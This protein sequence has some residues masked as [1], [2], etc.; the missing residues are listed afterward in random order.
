MSVPH[1]LP[2]VADAPYRLRPLTQADVTA[3]YDYLSIPAVVEHTSWNL[4]SADDLR[5][6][7]EWYLSD[8]PSSAI[9]FAIQLRSGGP[10]IGTIGFHTISTLNRSAEIAYDLH[11]AHWGRGIASACCRAVVKWGVER[12]G[13]VRVQ[14]TVLDTNTASAR[15]L[16]KAGFLL[17]GTLRCY[18]IVRN[19]PRDFRLYSFV[20]P[21]RITNENPDQ[22]EVRALIGE[23][24]RYQQALYPAESNH[25]VDVSTLAQSHVRFAVARDAQGRAVG[26]GAVMLMSDHAEIKRMFVRPDQRGNGVGRKLLEH[27]EAEA[28]QAGLSMLRLETGIHQPE[29]LALYERAGYVRCG[30]FGEYAED[31]LSVFMEKRLG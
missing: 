14:A 23:L 31:P 12:R 20:M 24:D 21:I 3:W 26:C 13:F 18:R 17:E 7:V 10:L 5:P 8:D 27:V 28:L 1:E 22:P 9:R 29:A 6:L 4:K 19:Q 11:P 30:P 15:V 16:E 25:F 2:S